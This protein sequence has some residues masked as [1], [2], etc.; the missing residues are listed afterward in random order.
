MFC[1][2]CGNQVDEKAVICVKCGAKLEPLKSTK[3]S[4]SSDIFMYIPL[5][6]GIASLVLCW[7]GVG[8]PCALVSI[9]MAIVFRAS[10]GKGVSKKYHFTAGIICSVISVVLQIVFLALGIAAMIMPIFFIDTFSL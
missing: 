4:D 10:D 7:T 3:S 8:I 9:I 5:V 2:S 1:P 6:A